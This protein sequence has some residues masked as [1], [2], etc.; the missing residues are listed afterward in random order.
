ME[1]SAA[2]PADPEDLKFAEEIAREAGLLTLG[3]FR[4]TDLVVEDKEDGTPV[5]AADRKA[6]RLLRER[7]KDTHKN[8]AIVGEEEAD[9]E[10]TSGRTWILD[11]IDGTQSFV[12]GVPLYAN[13]VAL[14]DEHGPAVGVINIPAL[15]ECVSAGR[16]LGCFM[17][18]EP[19]QVSKQTNL[20]SACIVT[21][22]ID[23]WP[24]AV[25]LD[26]LISAGALIR[27]WGDAYGYVLVA[28]GRAHAMVDPIVSR[29]DVAPMLTIFPEAGGVFTDL[30]GKVTA[31][32][33][34]ALATNALLAPKIL[35][36]IGR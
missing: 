10:G 18:D 20:S 16:G 36:I 29:W 9:T 25:L 4:Q 11:P 3:L 35:E 21:S 28:T 32:G 33:G 23:Y 7:I 27:T 8:D 19:T 24:S 31:E 6:E 22:G 5:T 30:S 14:E 1:K 34:D 26:Q 17:N 13:L 15:N 12:H 2:P